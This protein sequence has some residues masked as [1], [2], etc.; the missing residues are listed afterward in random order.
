[1]ITLAFRQKKAIENQGFGGLSHILS[2]VIML[3]CISWFLLPSVSYAEKIRS[4]SA[5]VVDATTGKVLYAKNPNL[6]LRPAST[7]KLMTAIVAIEN[8]NFTD[9]TTVSKRAVR[10]SP[11]KVGLK[12][13]DRVSIETLLYAALVKSGND[14]AAVLAEAV[15]GSER[16]FVQLMNR[17]AA[18][19]G[20][21]NTKFKNP[22][23]LPSP[24]QYTTASDLSKIMT[25]A[26]TYPRLREI[27][28]T[29][30]VEVL[31]ENG[32]AIFLKNTNKLLWS[33]DDLIG[34]KTGYTRRARHCFVC[35]A[36]RGD[37]KLIVVVLGSP[38]R[39]TLWK[40]SGK[41]LHEGF[42]VILNGKDHFIYSETSGDDLPDIK[43]ASHNKKTNHRAKNSNK[44]SERDIIAKKIVREKKQK[45]ERNHREAVT[46]SK[47]K[48]ERNYRIAEKSK[49]D[50]QG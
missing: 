34:G 44:N 37:S 30:V 19:I 2:F 49:I 36:E 11:S 9:I 14:A 4:R 25:Y 43:E 17:K 32:H 26:L 3:A 20:A 33:E 28:G 41:L 35:A 45:I 48:R 47:E 13:G 23:G 21:K 1:V 27:I 22:H 42:E 29:R 16:K 46:K 15:A 6:K 40:E 8:A 5:L 12:V 18:E 24:G 38:N 10:V 50:T 7:V 31:T 39:K